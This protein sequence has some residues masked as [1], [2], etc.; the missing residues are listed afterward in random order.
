ML[1]VTWDGI[2]RKQRD[3]VVYVHIVEWDKR[4]MW[5][6]S[7]TFNCRCVCRTLC[8]TYD[9][10]M[11]KILLKSVILKGINYEWEFSKD[12]TFSLKFILD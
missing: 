4:I 11:L 9:W 12:D 3:S 5:F 7:I 10:I 2:I 8:M 1:V 6:I